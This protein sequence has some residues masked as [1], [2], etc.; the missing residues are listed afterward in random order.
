MSRHRTSPPQAPARRALRAAARPALALCLVARAAAA[1]AQGV[2]VHPA[3]ESTLS[4]TDNGA[5]TPS[6]EERKDLVGWVRP[7]VAIDADTRLYKLHALVGGELI[8]YAN[9]TQP[10]HAYPVLLADGTGTLVERLL[11]L[12]AST[13]VRAAERDPYA[14]RSEIGS[15]LNREVTS[16]YRLSPYLNWDVSSAS[17][18][19]ARLEEVVSRGDTGSATNQRYTNVDLNWTT[20]P[21]PIGGSVAVESHA[22]RYSF[23]A[24]S[25]VRI[26]TMKASGDV[27]V[28]GEFIVGPSVGAERTSFESDSQTDTYYGAHVRWSPNERT[29]AAA[30]LE[31]RFF[32]TGWKL[33]LRHRAPYATVLV[34]WERAPVTTSQSLGVV[35]SASGLDAFLD[36]ILTTRYPDP[37]A[38]AAVVGNVVANRG[39]Q[40]D[41]QGAIDVRANYAQ[42]QNNFNANLVFLGSRNIVTVGVYV[43]TLRGLTRDGDVLATALPSLSDSRQVGASVDFNR[44]LT[45]LLTADLTSTWSRITGLADAT[46][47]STTQQSH[48]LAL[49]RAL[50]PRTTVSVGIRRDALHSRLTA[51]QSY[52]ANSAFV[53]MN[54]KF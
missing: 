51:V 5:G 52:A 22:V 40:S 28:G 21:L 8:G 13:S 4:A 36:A 20:R 37:T 29:Q 16:V 12:D 50:S 6:G 42:L 41:A 47:Q 54:H 49:V 43:L 27:A 24:D 14:A 9:G 44:K 3:V 17:K 10:N 39:L 15:T 33:E 11:F 35:S 34:T 32:G 45:P 31:H 18:L 25:T 30:E 48:R 53:G 1:L 19:Y 7:T 26:D 46:G 2:E 23:P 38:R